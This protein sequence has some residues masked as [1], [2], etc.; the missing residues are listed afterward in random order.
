MAVITQF[1]RFGAF[2]MRFVIVVS[3]L[4]LS[5]CASGGPTGKEVLSSS[6][7]PQQSRIVMYRTNPLGFA[8]QP[9]YVI[10]GKNVGPSQPNGFVVCNVTPGSHKVSVANLA[11]NVNFGGGTDKATVNVPAGQ[12]VYFIAEPK[13]GL[14]VGVITITQVAAAQGRSD[15]APLHKVGSC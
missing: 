13:M 7:A 5:A 3:C 11:L 1:N 2:S 4:L 9:N 15:T 12:T 10:N 6:L 14:T 8:V